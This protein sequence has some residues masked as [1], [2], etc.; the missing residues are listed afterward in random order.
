MSFKSLRYNKGITQHDVAEK[1]NVTQSAVSRWE[2]GKYKPCRK[3]R[4][5][6]AQLFGCTVDELLSDEKGV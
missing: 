5:V 6:L 2:N 4:S 1:L 3:Y